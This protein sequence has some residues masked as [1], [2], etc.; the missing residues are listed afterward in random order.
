MAPKIR[1]D[2][3]VEVMSGKDAGKRGKVLRVDPRKSRLY[4]EGLNIVK[5]HERPRSLKQ[6]QRTAPR[7]AE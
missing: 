4:V 1:K 2:D 3:T 6:T 5:R 7:S